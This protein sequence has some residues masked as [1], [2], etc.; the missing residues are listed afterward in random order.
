MQQGRHLHFSTK[1]NENEWLTFG[2]S[3]SDPRGCLWLNW[4]S[5]SRSHGVTLKTSAV[6]ISWD[7]LHIA[8]LSSSWQGVQIGERLL[9]TISKQKKEDNPCSE[10]K[11]LHIGL[12]WGRTIRKASVPVSLCSHP[13]RHQTRTHWWGGRTD[14]QNAYTRTWRKNKIVLMLV[15]REL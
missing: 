13:Y 3:A 10:M 12:D 15:N 6:T 5:C 4:G 1:G 11:N 7:S 14:S 2:Q 9:F 8:N